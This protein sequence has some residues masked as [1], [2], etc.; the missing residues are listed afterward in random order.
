VQEFASEFDPEMLQATSLRKVVRKVA[1]R[2]DVP[3]DIKVRCRDLLDVWKA[4]DVSDRSQANE[5][6]SKREAGFG[7]SDAAGEILREFDI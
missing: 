3:G 7:L 5:C 4:R 6:P 2:T 1:E